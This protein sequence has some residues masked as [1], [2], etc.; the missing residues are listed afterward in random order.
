MQDDGTREWVAVL[1][2][3]NGTVKIAYR[4]SS[5]LAQGLS[6]QTK[7]GWVVQRVY[8]R[9][10][11]AYDVTPM[12]PTRA[13]EAEKDATIKALADALWETGGDYPEVGWHTDRCL[14]DGVG[15]GAPCTDLCEK[16]R[17]ALRLAGRGT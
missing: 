4:S 14:V 10:R 17:S 16:R 12:T 3:G 5:L 11:Q 7:E 15:V 8:Q 9:D 13:S 1:Q 2:G 6:E